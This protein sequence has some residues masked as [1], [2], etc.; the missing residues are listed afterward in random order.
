MVSELALGSLGPRTIGGEGD[1]DGGVLVKMKGV[2]CSKLPKKSQ[3]LRVC[4][5]FG[6]S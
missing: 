2:A 4:V 5:C 1:R 3:G 6:L